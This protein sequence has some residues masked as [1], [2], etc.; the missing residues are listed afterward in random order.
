MCSVSFWKRRKR[1]LKS[2]MCKI[3]ICRLLS[4][5]NR[6]LFLCSKKFFYFFSEKRR[7]WVCILP[8]FVQI[9]ERTNPD[10]KSEPFTCSLKI[11]YTG[12]WDFNS[13]DFSHLSRYAKTLCLQRTSE[14]SCY[15]YWIAPDMAMTVR[16]IMILPYGAGG[17]PGRGE[18]PMK[19]NSY[20]LLSDLPTAFRLARGV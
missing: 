14:N 16:R 6:R 17:V 10:F 5:W 19:R 3:L 2:N 4:R 8:P 13:D 18:I 11:E 9:S 12:H 20:S 7:F 1:K 15:E